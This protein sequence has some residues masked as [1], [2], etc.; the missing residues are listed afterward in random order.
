MLE[1]S[2]TPAHPKQ[3]T[4]YNS[5]ALLQTAAETGSLGKETFVSKREDRGTHQ[6]RDSNQNFDDI[7][8]LLKRHKVRSKELRKVGSAILLQ[9][10]KDQ[11]IKTQVKSFFNPKYETRIESIKKELHDIKPPRPLV[12]E[13]PKVKRDS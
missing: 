4:V 2:K 1:K 11:L 10:K 8:K 12:Q 3:S 5:H 7:S 13:E 9:T 6:S